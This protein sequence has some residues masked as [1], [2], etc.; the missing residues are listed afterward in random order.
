MHHE[1]G[2]PSERLD[3]IFDTYVGPATALV[4]DMWRRLERAGRVRPVPPAVFHFLVTYGAAGPLT[5][6]A[7]AERFGRSGLPRGK[8]V[9][10]YANDVVDLLLHG[11]A[12]PAAA[13]AQR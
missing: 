5:M 6:P 4:T 2:A 12:A 8:N 7:L 13:R 9:T 11:M 3:Y 1:A 10:R